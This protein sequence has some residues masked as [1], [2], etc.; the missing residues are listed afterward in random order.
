MVLSL[1]LAQLITGL[2]VISVDKYTYGL[3][4]SLYITL[5]IY[6]YVHIYGNVSFCCTDGRLH[7][8]RLGDLGAVLSRHQL[9]EPHDRGPVLDPGVQPLARVLRQG[10]AGRS[11]TGRTFDKMADTQRL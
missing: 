7:H 2:C 1:S 9:S 10:L 8:A 6:M 11:M 4:L 3:S 5:S